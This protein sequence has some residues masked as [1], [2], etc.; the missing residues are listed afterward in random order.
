MPHQ[1]LSHNALLAQL[2][3]LA[4]QSLVLWPLSTGA[5]ARLMTLSENATFLVEGA[6]GR[7]FVLRIH[8]EGYHTGHAIRCELAWSSALN[9]T[10][11]VITP[12]VLLGKDGNAVQTAKCREMAQPRHMVMFDFIEGC[13]PD[14]NA[15]LVGPFTALGEIAAKTHHHSLRWQRPQNF[16]RLV[17]NETTIF[18]AAPIWGNWRDGPGVLAHHKEVLE[19]LE[20]RIM[21]RLQVFGKSAARYGLIH[22]DMRLANLLIHNG[23]PRLIDFDDCGFGWYLYDFAAGVSFM[24]DHPQ[25]PALKEA[26]VEGY[27]KARA[28]S[29]DEY[30]EIDTFVML[31]RMALLAWIGSHREV[32]LAQELAPTFCEKSVALA[33]AYLATNR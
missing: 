21:A 2:G 27:R 20:H 32:D 16:D 6:E 30:Q 17:W 10:G 9:D 1:V 8:R 26:W 3:R 22:A 28:L 31:R 7:K 4:T 33:E 5:T 23:A 15:D 25:V 18:G 29:D 14:E 19:A 24:E 12:T 13:A 11:G